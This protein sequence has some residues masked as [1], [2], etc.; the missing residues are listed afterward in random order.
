LLV[1]SAVPAADAPAAGALPPAPAIVM[2]VGERCLTTHEIEREIMSM[3]RP[4]LLRRKQMIEK[5][6][7]NQSLEAQLAAQSEALKRQVVIVL[8]TKAIM[9]EHARAQG[10]SPDELRLEERLR[11]RARQAGGVEALVKAEGRTLGEIRDNLRGDD[12]RARF[13]RNY[14]PDAVP[15]GP[16][17]IRE[18][19]TAHRDEIK[20]SAMVK[21][22]A[23]LLAKGDDEAGA[24]ATAERLK[25]ELQFAPD[26]FAERAR[27]HSDHRQTAESGGLIA[28]KFEGKETEWIGLDELLRQ[29]PLVGRAVAK[30]Q[31]GKVSDVLAF[32]DGF[33]LVKLEG[34]RQ[35][36]ILGIGEAADLIKDKLAAD[37][38]EKLVEDWVLYHLRSTYLADGRGRR[39]DVRTAPGR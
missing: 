24:L 14:V 23:I 38:R 10:H 11:R 6:T 37:A 9:E 36:G 2:H 17:E 25:R 30:L 12:M 26:R 35:G 1:S 39:V 29:N 32:A 34:I 3:L 16:R 19:Y 4:Q 33:A 20:A 27:E 8:R 7:W 21:V 15:P 31:P 28:G 13:M 18:Y 5:G 22:R